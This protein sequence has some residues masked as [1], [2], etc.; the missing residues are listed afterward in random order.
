M[1]SG[2]DPRHLFIDESGDSERTLLLCGLSLPES[3][4][5]AARA[6][7]DDLVEGLAAL[8]P[9]FAQQPE[10]KANRLARPLLPNEIARLGDSPP[11]HT[12]EREFVYQHALHHVAGLSAARVYSVLWH[13]K[14]PAARGGGRYRLLLERLMEWVLEGSEPV[15]KIV[16]DQAGQE[17]YYRRALDAVA[18]NASVEWTVEMPASH[19]D[20]LLQL[21]DLAAFAAW[22]AATPGQSH[23]KPHM[24]SWYRAPL[25]DLFAPHG[26]GY[27]LRHFDRDDARAKRNYG[28]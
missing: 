3:T 19:E 10:L 26:D 17:P 16:I 9:G 11:F 13:W 21:V 12:H 15:S 1:T 25:S 2:L 23:S 24:R 22:Q 7:T 27:G 6:T 14:G 28:C 20:R 18:A 5:S 8:L 4:V